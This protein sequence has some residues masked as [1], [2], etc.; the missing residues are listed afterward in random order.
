MQS[1]LTATVRRGRALLLSKASIVRFSLAVLSLAAGLVVC[2]MVLRLAYPRYQHLANP[3]VPRGLSFAPPYLWRAMYRRPDTSVEHRLLYN[4]LGNRQHRDFSEGELRA[5]LN[6]AFFGDSYTENR[7]IATQYAFPEVLD[8]LLNS[9]V[10]D[11]GDVPSRV[12]VLNF[13]VHGSGPDIQYLRYRGF[14]HKDLLRHVFY[15]HGNNDFYD[16]QNNLSRN[17]DGS[18]DLVEDATPRL[19]KR[20]YAR[21]HLTYLVLDVWHR[22]ARTNVV[23]SDASSRRVRETAADLQAIVLRW[24]EEV[25]ANGGSF[26][27]VLLPVAG[28]A[29][30]FASVGWPASLA[31]LDLHACFAEEMAGLAW[32]DLGFKTDSHWNEAGNM[33]AAH[34]LYRYLEGRLGLASVTNEALAGDRYVYYRAFAEDA[35]WLG[36]RWSPSA[37][38]TKLRPFNPTEAEAIRAKYLALVTDPRLSAVHIIRQDEPRVRAEGWEVYSSPERRLLVYVKSPCNDANPASRLFVRA[39]AANTDGRAAVDRANFLQGQLL[40]LGA[41]LV[42]R[43]GPQ[44]TVTHRLDYWPVA[45]VQTGEYAKHPG[46]AT[47]WQE[48]FRFDAAEVVAAVAE[49]FRRDYRAIAGREPKARSGGWE[50]HVSDTEIAYVRQRCI[51]DDWQEPFFLG[52]LPTTLDEVMGIRAGDG[53]VY[54]RIDFGRQYG[55]AAAVFDGKCLL[56]VRLPHW[57]VSTIATGQR[58]GAGGAVLWQ[59]TFHVDVERFQRAYALVNTRAPAASGAFDIHRVGGDLIYLREPCEAEDVQ[60]RFLLHVFPQSGKSQDDHGSPDFVNM[61]FDFA[62][63]GLRAD[64]RCVAVKPLPDYAIDRIRTGQFVAGEEQVWAVE[65]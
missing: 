11:G 16:I 10:A 64:G 52:I 2:E 31:V 28:T 30:Q 26:H 7:F 61:D 1:K 24:R 15:V 38:W 37:P 43:D 47:L 58:H 8:Y 63:R 33:L 17:W 19:L 53:F 55:H 41:A 18:M 49:R 6:V 40:G 13:G 29:R 36:H 50:I 27:V 4:N 32:Q 44:C 21:L 14:A 60:A 35:E 22:L 3:P 20:L 23:D 12:N 65:L 48:T 34:C 57:P 9:S 45:E 54:R 39:F 25:E 62:K 5:G 59:T 51:V 46:N 42:E 56:K